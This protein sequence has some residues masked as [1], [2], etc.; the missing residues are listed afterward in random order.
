MRDHFAI[1]ALRTH[2]KFHIAG[3][4]WNELVDIEATD[5]LKVMQTLESIIAG[6]IR[7]AARLWQAKM[8]SSPNCPLC[9]AQ[10]ED[11]NHTFWQCK[12]T[13]HI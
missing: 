2:L 13:V 4:K 7:G 12:A 6:S 8:L 11:Q 10:Q 5:D 3:A 9:G 1:T